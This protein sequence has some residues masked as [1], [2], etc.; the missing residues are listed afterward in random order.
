MKPSALASS[1][2]RFLVVIAACLCSGCANEERGDPAKEF[3]PV[4]WTRA[5]ADG[6]NATEIQVEI[7]HVKKCRANADENADEIHI[8]VRCSR[9]LPTCNRAP[10]GGTSVVVKLDRPIG[11]RRVADAMGDAS[12]T[13]CVPPQS[14]P[15]GDGESCKERR[16]AAI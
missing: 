13:V 8:D 16:S 6:R 7:S 10:C 12:R 1:T 9:L 15:L 3:V 2:L 4:S 14:V 5:W 11:S